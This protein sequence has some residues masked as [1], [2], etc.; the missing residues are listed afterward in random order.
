MGT[1]CMISSHSAWLSPFC[2]L[3]DCI[4]PYTLHAI[5]WSVGVGAWRYKYNTAE[6]L[7]G[8]YIDHEKNRQHK[9]DTIFNFKFVQILFCHYRK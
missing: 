9:F 8:A 5:I 1:D 3:P 6:I 2:L 4:G 7:S